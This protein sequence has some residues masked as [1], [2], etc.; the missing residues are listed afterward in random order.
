V[1]V[2][3]EPEFARLLAEARAALN[4][5][6]RVVVVTGEAG[7]GKT[8]LIDEALQRLLDQAERPDAHLP[9]F[10]TYIVECQ[11]YEQ[12]TPYAAVRD[13]L[14]QLFGLIP[15]AERSSTE[16]ISHRVAELTPELSRFTP[17]LADLLG[18]PFDDTPLTTALT[19]EQRHD[20]A[21]ELIEAIVLAESHRQPLAL[22]VDD[23]HWADAS[24]LELLAR[25]ARRA[26]R[27]PLLIVLGYRPDPAVAEPWRNLAH[28]SSLAIGEL[29][30]EA[31]ATLLRS[32]LRGEPPAALGSLAE[33]AQGNPFF[34]E[35]VVRS[36][37]ESNALRHEPDGWRLAR[38]L[39]EASIP[40]SI[41]GV[42][43]A[44][45]DRLEERNREVIQIAAVV[46]R[47]FPY[48]ILSG[49]VPRSDD[50]PERLQRLTGADLIHPDE[51]D[52]DLAYL[53]RH[54][55]TRDV[56]YESI[57]YARRRELHRRVARQIEQ[58]TPDRLDEQLALLARHYLLA[59]EW[60]AAFDYHLRAGRQAQARFAN[61]EAIA[62][63]ER[64]IEIATGS[65]ARSQEPG[66]SRGDPAHRPERRG[67]G[68]QG[69][70][71]PGRQGAS[72]QQVGELAQPETLQADG[73]MV[74]FPPASLVEIHER[75]G[76]I[77]AL[78]GEYDRALAQYE[79]ARRLLGQQANPPVDNLVRLHHHIA[80]VFE[81]RSDFEAAFVWVDQA[82]ALAGQAQNI[83]VARCLLL[84]AGLHQ[85]QG[86]YQQA[87]A[88]GERALSL[89]EAIGSQREQAHALKL[90]GGTHRNLGDNLQAF[91][92]LGR[93]LALYEQVQDLDGVSYAHN[94]LANICYELGRLAEA[95]THYEAGA[96]IKQAIGDVYGQALIANNL[97]N[98][99]RLLDQV[100]AAIAQYQRSLTIFEQLGSRYAG[101]V[102]HMNLGATEVM[103]GDLAR[104]EEHLGRSA[105]L[106]HQ[107]GA[108]DFLPE[109]ERCLAELHVRRGNLAE[110]RL[111]CELSLTHA[112]TLAARAEE[113]M[114]RRVLGQIAVSG[115]DLAG[116]WE[117]L[118]H[119]LAILR[120]VVSS[121]EVAR[122]LLAIAD[123]A[124]AVGRRDEGQS[125]L[126]EALP[127]LREA[128][129][130]RDLAE[131]RTIAARHGYA[132]E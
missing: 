96:E 88:W 118:A 43:T 73:T 18:V 124:P 11:S 112:T 23:L 111:A 32:L 38:P 55:L 50:L 41:E 22:I 26:P 49:V 24:S 45:L 29:T 109:L 105:E 100:D 58:H 54:A 74:T 81:K 123:L 59:E 27:A 5:S 10:F 84:G 120:E 3:R 75:L 40:D 122:T 83:E 35:E 80:R 16:A 2:G 92:L 130:I 125:A 126:A 1:F 115:G 71:E 66:A 70:E 60:A 102:L 97:G 110:A 64:A 31:S 28:C 47:R 52:R 56:A 82:L 17:L 93:S 85:R 36:L 9:A 20:R 103:R 69:D 44:R 67:A 117:E 25:L 34:I 6:G 63:L 19:P 131:A 4:G 78:V 51:I 77:H 86:R 62:L 129:A 57:L 68:E 107:A 132:T 7:S 89:A 94:D 39:D 12:S 95:R 90:L 108:E 33:K 127:L 21:Q 61:R 46:G 128:G 79:E 15:S 53:F 72:S 116:A 65:G 14:R 114:T 76:V 119:S 99:L 91:D 13:L 98:T 106:F 30:A 37:I 101:G 42:I 8:R 87:I 104:A 113:G 48:P 121:L